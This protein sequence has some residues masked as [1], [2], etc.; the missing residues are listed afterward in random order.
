MKK[1]LAF[2]LLI[3]VC[4]SPTIFAQIPVNILA[5]I[6]KAE[7]ELRYDA[8]LENLMKDAAAQVR[9][10]AALA[11]GRIGDE[12]AIPALANLLQKDKDV[13]ARAMA[14]FALGEIESIKAADAILSGLKNNENA[15]AVRARAI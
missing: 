5:Q 6:S 15:D 8:G 4:F 12:D 14:A 1:N 2:C 11:A 7:D 3:L 10:R 9:T 13:K